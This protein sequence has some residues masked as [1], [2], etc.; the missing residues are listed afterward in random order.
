MAS[1]EAG[2]G[3]AAPDIKKRALHSFA[4]I[5]SLVDD[6]GTPLGPDL[7]RTA[8]IIRQ[9]TV[10]SLERNFKALNHVPA[11]ATGSFFGSTT[12]P[13]LRCGDT[14]S[15]LPWLMNDI[16]D[17]NNDRLLTDE[18]MNS[19]NQRKAREAHEKGEAAPAPHPYQRFK[20]QQVPGG[21]VE[22]IKKI[23]GG[24]FGAIFQ[25]E[26]GEI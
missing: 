7:G 26:T 25:S 10:G 13:I 19:Y 3:A 2:G 23:S 14:A 17:V 6:S 11:N 5:I 18:Q 16:P 9:L 22:I 15:Q 1:A 24:T 8:E 4:E 21:P 20:I 12:M